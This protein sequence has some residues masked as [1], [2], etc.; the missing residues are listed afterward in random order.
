MNYPL[1]F[2]R[3]LPLH[4]QRIFF[5][6]P[7]PGPFQGRGSLLPAVLN[8]FQKWVSSVVCRLIIYP[9]SFLSFVFF[10]PLHNERIWFE[11]ME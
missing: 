9:L 3:F 10:L 7:H 8:R 6:Q 2:A 1:S 4:M 5:E 11:Q